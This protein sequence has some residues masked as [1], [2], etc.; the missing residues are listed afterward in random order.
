MI[1]KFRTLSLDMKECVAYILVA[2][3]CLA[4]SCTSDQVPQQQVAEDVSPFL[5]YPD[6]TSFAE[7]ATG[8]VW[9]GTSYGLNRALNYGY[10]QYFAGSDSPALNNHITSLFCDQKGRLWVTGK[11]GNL[12]YLSEDGHFH[13]VT[14]DYHEKVRMSFLEMSGERLF[15]NDGHGIYRY[16]AQNEAMEEIVSCPNI[17]VGLFS[18][19]ENLIV[20]YE[21]RICFYSSA[22]GSFLGEH[23]LE[24]KCTDAA[25]S[26]DG[27]LWLSS[28]TS[29]GLRI[30]Q[31]RTMQELEVPKSL[32]DALA[33]RSVVQVIGDRFGGET[34]LV[35]V[36]DDVL[37]YNPETGRVY[38]LIGSGYFTELQSRSVNAVFYDSQDNI[39]LGTN[40]GGVQ[41]IKNVHRWMRF[42]VLREYFKHT[43]I[44]DIAF[45]E[46]ENAV[47]LVDY[48]GQWYRYDLDD[49]KVVPIPASVSV[50]DKS[51]RTL[52][53][54]DG[55]ILSVN[56]NM[57]LLFSSA[58][59]SL[60]NLFPVQKVLDALGAKLFHPTTMLEDSKGKI[61]I[62][63][64]STGA[65][66]ID[67]ENNNIRCINEVKGKDVSTILEDSLGHVWVATKNGLYSYDL[68]GELL[69]RYFREGYEGENA[70]MDNCYCILPD[71]IILLGTMR[72]VVI[73]NP[74][75]GRESQKE[76]FCM[77]DLRVHNVLVTP[78]KDAPIDKLMPFSP[79]VRLKHNQNAFS[80]SFSSLNYSNP[81]EGAYSYILEGFDQHWIDS[82]TQ[83]EA[84]YSNVPPGKYTFRARISSAKGDSAIGSASCE[85]VILP[86]P[87]L[88]FPAKVAYWLL[89]S[90]LI[91]LGVLSYVRSHRNKQEML[92]IANEKKQEQ[93]MNDIIKKYFANVAHQLR[94]PLTMI[95]GPVDMLYSRANLSGQDKDLLR[96]L[97]Y[98]T[99][100]MLGLVNQIMNFHSLES[101]ALALQVSR[102]DLV[103]PLLKAMDIYK[104][105]AR[106]KN[107]SFVTAGFEENIFAYADIDKV[108]EILDNL[109]SNALKFTPE[110]GDVSVSLSIIDG[111][112]AQLDVANNGKSLPKGHEEIVF[113]RFYREEEASGRKGNRGTGVGLY[114]ARKLA[115][116][117]H[118]DLTCKN[119]ENDEG[120]CFSLRIPVG[121]EAFTPEEIVDVSK[122]I[123][124]V[125]APLEELDEIA[126]EEVNDP[127]AILKPKVLLVDDDIDINYYLRTLLLS[128]FQ[129]RCCYDAESALV[130]LE[131][132]APDLIISDIMMTGMSGL[133]FC[134]RIKGDL[135]YCHIPLILLTAKD[136]VQDQIEGIS[137]GADA[138][139]TK[140]FHAD[141][142]ITLATNLV[143]SRVQLRAQLSE[144]VGMATG[145]DNTLSPQDRAF[146]E[147]LYAI[148]DE[149][150][151][152]S[153]F[154]IAAAVEQMHISHTKFIYKVK[155][156]TGFTPSELFKNYKLNKA[157][158]MIKE[159]K[160]NVSEVAD[161][162]GFGTLAYFS[163]AFKKK[164][165]VSPSEYK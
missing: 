72:G 89:F 17:N 139:V 43:P 148:W 126:P 156:L 105:N 16:S 93:Q 142:L 137:V 9:I 29:G 96:V 151:S 39:W 33:G 31:L 28:P 136:G 103:T 45:D 113:T 129:V 48:K 90:T 127:T 158:A 84:F 128:S 34:L 32:S 120:V 46:K 2:F 140:P 94:T 67:Q 25:I 131:K 88:S 37:H 159:G 38:K 164:F 95:Y 116:L 42:H 53:L 59:K 138:Y 14:I 165:G 8:H 82:G 107:I 145:N 40:V 135:Q 62:G 141:Y 76:V 55:R 7:D 109:L 111:S 80:I 61:W 124:K 5:S 146:L 26:P 3:T 24:Y 78:G 108:T 56:D 121:K 143:K 69:D 125:K 30:V 117:H 73:V 157:A 63:T 35:N 102:C 22:N 118:G 36:R 155:G 57:D 27:N 21:D 91:G 50:P 104:I 81:Y 87:W 15:C 58:D 79:Q 97:R 122:S 52:F 130:E 64:K 132:D 4:I 152:N 13:Q 71:G 154:N 60:A 41:I 1:L 144:T 23:M 68:D 150:L 85:V 11:R 99:D 74:F 75:V 101:D 92:R 66:V 10:H 54:R 83:H 147:Q 163:R 77:E 70:Y 123:E 153:D 160:Y 19:G 6:V 114:Y 51:S 162:A 49:S 47:R 18:F 112:Y 106:E 44:S 133:E 100:R 110:G 149:Q 12:C 134:S 115:V 161:M 86:A 65:L 119:L 98:N 20:V